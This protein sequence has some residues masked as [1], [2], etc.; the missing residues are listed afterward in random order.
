MQDFANTA[1]MVTMQVGD[2][3]FFYVSH[4]VIRYLE[5]PGQRLVRTNVEFEYVALDKPGKPGRPI[6]RVCYD[7]PVLTGIKEN[8]SI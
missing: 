7:S 8:Q 1:D 3:S 4:R 6:I 5:L 2:D